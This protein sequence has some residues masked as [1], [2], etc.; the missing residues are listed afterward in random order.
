[1]PTSYSCCEICDIT[2]ANRPI[3]KLESTLLCY[4]CAKSEEVKQNRIVSEKTELI[5]QSRSN[6]YN[7]EIEIYNK[8]R[9]SI[10]SNHSDDKGCL[11]ILILA[12]IFM[13]SHLFS[14]TRETVWVVYNIILGVIALGWYIYITSTRRENEEL[15]SE[16]KQMKKA[17]NQPEIQYAKP[18]EIS[19][20]HRP[21]PTDSTP[22]NNYRKEVLERD[23]YTCQSC[24][25]K[26]ASK[27]L[28]V[29][30]VKPQSQGGDDFLTNLVCLCISCHDREKWFG[31]RRKYPTTI[32]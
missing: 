4:R 13:I 18:V 2:L 11:V 28:E 23:Q 29:H 7:K 8:Q 31:H 27:N 32:K 14:N 16:L 17:P 22:S 3:I 30:H 19:I 20:F 24:S 21:V 12:S 5:N 9:S 15:E 1:M 25:A 10:L 26:K 6:T